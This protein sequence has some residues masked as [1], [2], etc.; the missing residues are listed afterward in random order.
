M[1]ATILR[2]GTDNAR[3]R[4][5]ILLISSRRARAVIVLE[6]EINGGDVQRHQVLPHQLRVE[7]ALASEGH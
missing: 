6:E 1:R 5:K 4:V 3:S 7:H 2:I